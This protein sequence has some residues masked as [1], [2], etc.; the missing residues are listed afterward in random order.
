[1]LHSEL[2][3][4]PKECQKRCPAQRAKAGSIV[5]A[6]FAGAPDQAPFVSDASTLK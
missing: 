5:K 6:M 3:Q 1:L 4:P 2:M